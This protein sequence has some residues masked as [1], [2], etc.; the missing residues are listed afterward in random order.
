[1]LNMNYYNAFLLLL[2]SIIYLNNIF[3]W[4]NK[5]F[6]KMIFDIGIEIN[7][8]SWAAII[9]TAWYSALEIYKYVK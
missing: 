7:T 9:F 4:K 1:M 5:T 6:D 8:P 2:D 3:L